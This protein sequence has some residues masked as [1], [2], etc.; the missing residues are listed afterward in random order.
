MTGGTTVPCPLSYLWAG[1][2][3]HIGYYP[4][5]PHIIQTTII[6]TLGTSLIV[7]GWSHTIFFIMLQVQGYWSVCLF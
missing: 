4:V 2:S 3:I 7:S 6:L 1:S 5:D